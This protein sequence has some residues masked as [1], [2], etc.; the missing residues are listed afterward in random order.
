VKKIFIEN[1]HKYIEGKNMTMNIT[2]KDGEFF[3]DLLMQDL[4][5]DEAGSALTTPTQLKQALRDGFL[6][7]SKSFAMQLQ[8]MHDLKPFDKKKWKKRTYRGGLF[9][10]DDIIDMTLLTGVKTLRERKKM[11]INP[12]K[13]RVALLLDVSY[14]MHRSKV[15]RASLLLGIAL[16]ELLGEGFAESLSYGTIGGTVCEYRS[17]EDFKDIQRRIL[18]ADFCEG[19][20]NFS[21]VLDE[22]EAQDFYNTRIT[23]YIFLITDGVPE[24]HGVS[25]Q[26][27]SQGILPYNPSASLKD[28]E[29]TIDYI[30]NRWRNDDRVEY[31][32]IQIGRVPTFLEWVCLFNYC[33]IVRTECPWIKEDE[34]NIWVASSD[35][36]DKLQKSNLVLAQGTGEHYNYRLWVKFCLDQYAQGDMFYMTVDD[37]KKNGIHSLVDYF[38]LKFQ[39]KI[40]I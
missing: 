23:K 6:E 14:S 10:V 25:I 35:Y 39:K 24:N 33:P 20:T 32:W 34:W 3:D 21:P 30:T 37:L 5:T 26:H 2:F 36:A 18:T 11:R 15:K 1:N 27:A 38:K 4:I 16:T 7:A 19:S 29:I 9:D 31:F 12:D 13:P 8:Q 40:Q 17:R 28:I 22:M